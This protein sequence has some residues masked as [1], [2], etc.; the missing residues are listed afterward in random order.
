MRDRPEQRTFSVA[1]SRP[2]PTGT[3]V[4]VVW[5]SVVGVNYFLERSTS[6][7]PPAF[8]ALATNIPGQQGTTSFTDTNASGTG[9]FFYRVGVGN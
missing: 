4:V 1:D 6:L 9:P 3:N 2:S 7:T 5:Q 8:S